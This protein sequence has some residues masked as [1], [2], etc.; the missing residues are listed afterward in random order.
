MPIPA[1]VQAGTGAAV[2]TGAGSV[3]LAGCT[4]GNLLLMD[5]VEKGMTGD[6][7]GPPSASNVE[8]LDGSDGFFD[9]VASN[10]GIGNPSVAQRFLY[11]ARVIANGTCS[12]TLTV[13]ASGNDLFARIYEFFGASTGTTTAAVFDSYFGGEAN[14]TASVLDA[15]VTTGGVDR[16]ALQFVALVANRL[17]KLRGGD[18]GGL[19]GDHARVRVCLRG[20][21]AASGVGHSDRRDDQRRYLTITGGVGHLGDMPGPWCG[22]ADRSP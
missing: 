8:R 4:A 9:A 20:D 21:H 19:D 16:Y 15:A 14:T 1:F 13:G 17:G 7:A 11:A 10:R 6:W 12:G 5:I 2:L 22:W 3:S 18:R